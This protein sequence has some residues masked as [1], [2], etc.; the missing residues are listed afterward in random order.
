MK[1]I[2]QSHIVLHTFSYSVF[3]VN[4]TG[5]AK[6]GMHKNTSQRAV[7]IRRWPPPLSNALRGHQNKTGPCWKLFWHLNTLNKFIFMTNVW[8]LWMS[9]NSPG[10]SPSCRNMQRLLRR[11]LEINETVSERCLSPPSQRHQRKNWSHLP[12]SPLA[13]RPLPLFPNQRRGK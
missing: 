4:K 13:V 1:K 7:L 10:C 6:S 5:F 3:Y 8:S 9:G 12:V 2:L 11:V